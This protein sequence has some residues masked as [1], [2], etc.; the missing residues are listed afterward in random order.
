[1]N[2]RD[3]PQ[4]GE[5]PARTS[6]L[7]LNR[8]LQIFLTIIAGAVVAI[9]AWDVITRFMHIIILL[10]GAFLLAYLLGPLVDRMERGGLGRLPAILVVYL[11]LLGS[12]AAGVVLLVGPLSSQIQGLVSALPGWT[13]PT[14]GIPAQIGTFLNQNGIPVDVASLIRNATDYLSGQASTLLGGTLAIVAGLVGFVT[15]LFLGLAIAFYLLLD[16]TAMRNRGLRLLPSTIREKWFF[17]EATLNKV[18]GGYIRGQIVVALTVGTAAGVGSALLGV[19]YPLVIGLLAFLFEFIP[20][21]GPVLGMIPAVVIA[22]FQSPT[23]ALWV[24]VYFIA[25]QQVESNVIVPR[26]SGRAV[27]LHPLAALLALLAGFELGGIGGAL[28]AVPIVGVLYVLGLAIYAD[29]TGDTGLLISRPPPRAY[30]ALRNVV[31]IRRGGGGRGSDG[32]E[33]AKVIA[34]PAQVRSDAAPTTARGQSAPIGDPL[35]TTGAQDGAGKSSSESGSAPGEDVSPGIE[36]VGNERLATITQEQAGL[37]AEFEAVE[38]KE[39]SEKKEAASAEKTQ[40]E[41]KGTNAN[42]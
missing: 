38:A 8:W 23:L 2:L 28:L 11:V 25:L 15:D 13:D 20:M 18:V 37:K 41:E 29:V 36:R 5:Q 35:I 39:A 19:Q 14:T 1:L 6:F 22:F 7:G 4:P 17:I 40:T 30:A 42:G 31:S 27:G 33:P 16:G 24:I 26:I 3:T 32:K 9:I 10:L 12:L 34:T 21:L